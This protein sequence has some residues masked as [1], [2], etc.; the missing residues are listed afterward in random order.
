M[1]PWTQWL[2]A[3]GVLVVLAPLLARMG[4]GLGKSAKGGLMLAS[5]LLGIG[6]VVDQP[7]KHATEE[8]ELAKGSPENDEPPLP[9]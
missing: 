8:T 1:S 9:R 6:E 4:R 2:I 7:A 3:L 5:V